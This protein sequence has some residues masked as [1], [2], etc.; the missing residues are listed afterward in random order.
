M[1]HRS[2]WSRRLYS[3]TNSPCPLSKAAKPPTVCWDPMAQ[4]LGDEFQFDAVN[5]TLS[6]WPAQDDPRRTQ[7]QLLARDGEGREVVKAIQITL[8]HAPAVQRMLDLAK[9]PTGQT[10]V[11]QLPRDAITDL[12]GDIVAFRMTGRGGQAFPPGSATTFAQQ[13]ITVQPPLGQAQ[14]LPI[15]GVHEMQRVRKP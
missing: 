13:T 8:R 7:L 11:L 3:G 9:V 5:R 4:P 6:W 10:T 2:V 12:D 14:D 1:T 15:S